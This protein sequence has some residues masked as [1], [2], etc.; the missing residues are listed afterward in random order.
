MRRLFEPARVAVLTLLIG[1]VVLGLV[2]LQGRKATA[3]VHY[4]APGNPIRIA[5]TFDTLWSDTGLDQLLQA[6]G[7]EQVRATFFITGDW[8]Q[9]HPQSAAAILKQGHEIGIRSLSRALHPDFEKDDPR[10]EISG[11]KNLAGETLEYRPVLFRPAGDGL[12][13]LLLEAVRRESCRTVLWS[14]ESYDWLSLSGEE[15]AF[16]VAERVHGG[17]IINFRVGARFLPA[18]VPIL[19][20]MLREQGFEPVTVSELLNERPG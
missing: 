2:A 12:T 15:I 18:A 9:R 20:R 7:R 14:V 17:A 10:E 4:F 13:G 19:A 3:T 5:L 1:L 8:L 6:L 11:F 16:R